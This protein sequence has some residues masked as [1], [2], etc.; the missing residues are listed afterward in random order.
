MNL[1]DEIQAT[2][3]QLAEAI[4]AGDASRAITLYT[5]DAR[6]IPHGGP[7]CASRDAIRAFLDGAVQSG[8]NAARF[9]TQEVDGD[10]AQAVEIGRY[11]LFAPTP[12]GDRMRV[13]DGRYMMV[14]RKV[15]QDWRIHRDMFG[16]Q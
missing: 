12:E 16:P 14:W 7:I 4:S 11:E 9:T 13:A 5:D 2:H 8:V 15:G 6:V 3:N 10:N 1:K